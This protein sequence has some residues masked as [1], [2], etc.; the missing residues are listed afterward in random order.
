[1]VMFLADLGLEFALIR[2]TIIFFIFSILIYVYF[3]LALMFIAK[4]TGTKYSWLAWIPYANIYLVSQIARK[5]WWPILL[6][7][8]LFISNFFSNIILSIIGLICGIILFVF[9]FIWWWNICEIRGKPGWWILLFLIPI[10]NF[11]WFFIFLGILAWGKDN[12]KPSPSANVN[13]NH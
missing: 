2:M 1:M 10:F 7:I 6:I 4:R 5:H 13:V 3:A 9:G 8:P 12:A 11:I